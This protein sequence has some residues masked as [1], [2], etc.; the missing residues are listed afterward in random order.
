M[1]SNGKEVKSTTEQ[2]QKKETGPKGHKKYGYQ[3]GPGEGPTGP[4]GPGGY[5]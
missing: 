1:D 5:Y 4:A 3:W 2:Q